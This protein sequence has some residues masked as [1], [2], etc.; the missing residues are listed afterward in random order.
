MAERT[1]SCQ[2][3]LELE[4]GLAYYENGDEHQGYDYAQG[5]WDTVK[6]ETWEPGE[7]YEDDG[8]GYYPDGV[9]RTLTDEQVAMFRHS[10]I[11]AV[12]RQRQVEKENLEAD[13]REE[14]EE[15]DVE[16][17]EGNDKVYSRVVRNGLTTSVD[18]LLLPEISDSMRLDHGSSHGPADEADKGLQRS[19]FVDDQMPPSILQ[20]SSTNAH[21]NPGIEKGPA[22]TGKKRKRS[23]RDM[24]ADDT[25]DVNRERKSRAQIRE[26]DAVAAEEQALDYGDGAMEYGDDDLSEAKVLNVLDD[27][28]SRRGKKVWWP[29]LGE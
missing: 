9:K 7:D 27:E 10:E 28:P 11:Y 20:T 15:R 3:G 1:R 12:H 23:N 16:F 26:L 8:L 4:D 19:L 2:N 14:R 25:D 17:N 18:S 5:R 13:Q 21:S 29:V 24:D 22:M 6:V